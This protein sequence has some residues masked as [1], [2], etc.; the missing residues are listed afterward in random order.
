MFSLRPAAG[1]CSQ[2]GRCFDEKEL[3]P[4]LARKVF[5]E[6][7]L[8]DD[9]PGSGKGCSQACGGEGL[10]GFP[11]F[12]LYTRKSSLG[13]WCKIQR[14]DFASPIAATIMPSVGMLPLSWA[15]QW[16]II[17]HG[18]KHYCIGMP[19]KFVVSAV[20]IRLRQLTSSP[21]ENTKWRL[22]PMR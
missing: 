15:F 12:I 11:K 18:R 1:L 7:S 14:S 2:C 9:Q 16:S 10:S 4:A 6:V 8:G 22:F 17:M 13:S 5:G 19:P 20:D 3:I 21:G